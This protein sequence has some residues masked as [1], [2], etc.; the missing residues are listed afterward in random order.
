MATEFELIQRYF[1]REPRGAVLGI[2]DDA[3]VLKPSAD[4][5]LVVTTD[6]LVE[7]NHFA[8][9]AD[10]EALGYKA[11]AVNLSDLAA[12][13]ARPRWTL[14][15][16]TLPKA[17]DD[18][19]SRFARGFLALADAFEVDLIGG[20]TTR[21]PLSICVTAL[22]EVAC[23]A[24]LRRDGARAGDAIWVSGVI[25]SAGLALQHL[26][27][28]VRLKEPDL[29]KCLAKLHTPKPRVALG[30]RLAGIATSAID[31]SDGLVADLGHIAERSKVRA[32]VEYPMVP[33]ISSAVSIKGHDPVRR[34]ILGGGDDYELCFTVPPDRAR[35]LAKL[36]GE[37]GVGL[38]RIGRIEAGNGVV[39]L[40]A[41]GVAI[42]VGE[43][44]FDH[45]R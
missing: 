15:A 3:A 20:D 33:C 22:G 4:R 31:V 16:L 7:G 6:T 11:L 13:G 36:S 8:A 9:D 45:F 34:A 24:A 12:M 39:V 30:Q 38:T 43:A 2:G 1:T 18:W 23:A 28:E 37:I 29:G 17:D 42:P 14:L 32:V 5:D 21:G 26:K 25:G 19:L 27:G 35:D 44:G 10:P 41:R 40:D